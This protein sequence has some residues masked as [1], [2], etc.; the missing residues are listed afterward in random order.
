MSEAISKCK[1]SKQG[2]RLDVCLCVLGI[3]VSICL[4]P[5]FSIAE[6]ATLGR[7]E[8]TTLFEGNNV[9]SQCFG[10]ATNQKTSDVHFLKPSGGA[11]AAE[12]P[13]GT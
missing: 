13:P 5:A 10:V 2:L 3:L 11:I 6:A 4:C 9:A 1:L 12:V 7:I 8:I